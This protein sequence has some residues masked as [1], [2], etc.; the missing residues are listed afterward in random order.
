MH[1]AC[2]PRPPVY[3]RANKQEQEKQDGDTR[4]LALSQISRLKGCSSESATL[5]PRMR[6][7]VQNGEG[8]GTPDDC[9]ERAKI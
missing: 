5:S 3:G 1:A 4:G 7:R 6:D 9:P 8:G 2:E